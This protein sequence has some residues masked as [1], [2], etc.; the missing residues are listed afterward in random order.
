MVL[1]I[2][3]FC[4]DCA[5][6]S[7]PCWKARASFAVFKMKIRFWCEFPNKVNW[8]KFKKLI[9]F[10]TEVY[11]ACKD[12]G[13]FLKLRKKIKTRNIDAGVW[14]VLEKGYWFSGFLEKEYIDKL[15]EFRGL[16][17][18]IDIE[19]P[20]PGKGYSHL[21]FIEYFLKYTL[22]KGK[23]NTYLRGV[24]KELSKNNDIIMSGFPFPEFITKRYG[25]FFDKDIKKNYFVYTTFN[26]RWLR[27]LDRLYY[28][29]FIKKMLKKH[30][31]KVMFAVGLVGTGIFGNENTYENL[32][33]FRKDL[34][35]VKNSGAENLVIFDVSGILKKGEE[36]F[37]LVNGYS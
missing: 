28:R 23:N 11:I 26:P 16:K 21:K 13:E 17:I 22:R 27:W 7:L 33:E 31:K 9:K 15:K 34:E 6:F 5:I 12:R 29:R 35:M 32:D 36:W 2:S 37:N 1:E 30:N 8:K 10:K 18:K 20:F 25:D 14:P 3:D 19:P 24:I 4:F